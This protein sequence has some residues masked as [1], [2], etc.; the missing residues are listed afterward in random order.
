[1][2]AQEGFQGDREGI[3]IY[4]GKGGTGYIV[5]TDQIVGDSAYHLFPREGSGANPHD[6][7]QRVATIRGGA[8]ET[9]GIEVTSAPLGPGFPQG[10]LVAMNSVGRN[11]LIYNWKAVAAKVPKEPTRQ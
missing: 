1:V 9:D 4:A 10:L 8:D 5:C 3:A 7:S 6:H 11:F 2:F